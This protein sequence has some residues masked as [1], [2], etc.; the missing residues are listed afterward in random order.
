MSFTKHGVG[1]TPAEE[2]PTSKT[3]TLKSSDW[4]E[5]DQRELDSENEKG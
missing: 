5:Q 3:A 4:T 2:Q 1:E